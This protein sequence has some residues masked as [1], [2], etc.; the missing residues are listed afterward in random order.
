MYLDNILEGCEVME[1]KLY[2][3]YNYFNM[4]DIDDEDSVVVLKMNGF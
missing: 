3:D 1:M 4:K 2:K